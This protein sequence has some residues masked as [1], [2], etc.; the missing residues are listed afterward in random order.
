MRVESILAGHWVGGIVYLHHLFS[1]LVKEGG[2]GVMAVLGI[3]I[4]GNRENG[5]KKLFIGG[6]L[7]L[8]EVSLSSLQV[9]IVAH[10]VQT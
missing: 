9:L 6:K 10:A 3:G 2:Q 4:A 8:G 1:T 5:K 7:K